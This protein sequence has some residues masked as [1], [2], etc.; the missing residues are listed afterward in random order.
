MCWHEIKRNLTQ[1]VFK[2]TP[3]FYRYQNKRY[4]LNTMTPTLNLGKINLEL[5]IGDT[6]TAATI[7]NEKISVA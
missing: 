4:S 2:F 3:I 6:L 1:Q 5:T 7:A